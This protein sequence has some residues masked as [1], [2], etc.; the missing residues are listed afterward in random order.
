MAIKTTITCLPL[1]IIL[2]GCATSPPKPILYPNAHFNQV[3]QQVANQDI[4][5]C[6]AMAHSSGVNEKKEGEIGRNA[7]GGAA[8]GGAAAGAWGL[9]YGDALN[10]A[11]AGALAGAAAGTTRGAI[12]SSE[13]SPVF[14]NFV[15]KCLRDRGYEVIGWQ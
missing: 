7:A 12:K 14:K 1:A 5:S 6:R 2:L 8:I 15:Q 13:T 3:G 10:R 11:A 4:A 9:V